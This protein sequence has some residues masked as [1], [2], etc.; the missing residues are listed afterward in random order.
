MRVELEPFLVLASSTGTSS[1][2]T[3]VRVL[4]S[5]SDSTLQ[6]AVLVLPA[7]P[8]LVHCTSTVLIEWLVPVLRNTFV[9]TKATKLLVL[10]RTMY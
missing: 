6:H 2:S 5:A 1:T 4:V 10:Y 9:R 7:V 8:V 3:A